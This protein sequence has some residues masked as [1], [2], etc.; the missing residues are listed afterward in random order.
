MIKTIF[1]GDKFFSRGGGLRGVLPI[2][3]D[4]NQY[5]ENAGNGLGFFFK[6]RHSDPY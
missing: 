2:M 6:F 5:F 4:K 1:R 3:K